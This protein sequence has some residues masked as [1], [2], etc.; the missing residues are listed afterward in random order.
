[1]AENDLCSMRCAVTTGYNYALCAVHFR[2]AR[3]V[4]IFPAENEI[5]ENHVYMFGRKLKCTENTFSVVY[6][7]ENEFRS[8][9]I[10]G[11]ICVINLD[12]RSV[13]IC[14]Y[15]FGYIFRFTIRVPLL[16]Y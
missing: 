8:S 4:A 5:F 14:D 15:I 10:C 6:S 12:E 13:D 2:R 1:M 11:I 16:G 3:K 7:S 9:S